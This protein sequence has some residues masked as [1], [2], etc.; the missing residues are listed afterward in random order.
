MCGEIFHYNTQCPLRKKDKEEEEDQQVASTAID[1]LS[2]RLEE[3]F[4][5]IIE[6]PPGVRWGD[7]EL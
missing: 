4:A 6:M 1:M 2:S 7:L 3:E 5:M